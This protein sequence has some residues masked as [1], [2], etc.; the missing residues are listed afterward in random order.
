M[1]RVKGINESLVLKVSFCAGA[2]S[3]VIPSNTSSQQDT[4]NGVMVKDVDASREE[5]FMAKSRSEVARGAVP[6]DDPKPQAPLGA[7]RS[8]ASRRRALE[9]AM[10]PA[11][12]SMRTGGR[13][14]AGPSAGP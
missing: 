8:A 10:A 2:Q 5:E 1:I 13:T 12:R 14:A 6:P 11:T 7:P 9:G 3:S 4:V